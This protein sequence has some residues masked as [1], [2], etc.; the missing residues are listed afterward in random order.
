MWTI[1]TRV[2]VPIVL[3][4]VAAPAAFASQPCDAEFQQ[5]LHESQRFVDVLRVDKPGG[6]R[7]FA[8]DG[9]EFT[10][11]QVLWMQGRVRRVVRLCKRG[12][13]E[14]VAEAAAAL[15]DVRTFIQSKHR[16]T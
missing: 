1:W 5:Q 10:S 13:S 11:G 15:T 16:G 14:A 8:A 6:A 3:M 4:C 12:D 9:S 2:I 7:V